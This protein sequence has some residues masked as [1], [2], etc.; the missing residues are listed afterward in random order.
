MKGTTYTKLISRL[1]ARTLNAHGSIFLVLTYST[2]KQK[3]KKLAFEGQIFLPQEHTYGFI[4]L[5]NQ[6]SIA[7]KEELPFVGYETIERIAQQKPTP[8]KQLLVNPSK[9]SS[10]SIKQREKLAFLKLFPYYKKNQIICTE[11]QLLKNQTSLYSLNM[12]ANKSIAIPIGKVND[13]VETLS[14]H[15]ETVYSQFKKNVVSVGYIPSKKFL[16]SPSGARVYF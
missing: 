2:P 3:N 5:E 9:L 15:L 12:P 10:L 4:G 8:L 1:K 13:S 6:E 14:K 11:D 7:K 16:S